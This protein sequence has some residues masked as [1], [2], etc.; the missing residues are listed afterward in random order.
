MAHFPNCSHDLNS[1]NVN[2]INS[3][4]KLFQKVLSNVFCNLKNLHLCRARYMELWVFWITEENKWLKLQQALFT[5]VR[6]PF[7]KHGPAPGSTLYEVVQIHL[8][9][10]ELYRLYYDCGSLELAVS[11]NCVILWWTPITLERP[12]LLEN[13]YI[14]NYFSVQ[15]M[16]LSKKQSLYN[17]EVIKE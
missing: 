3:K 11:G 1:R 14:L 13:N 5:D 15:I 9:S 7:E 2:S 16:Y 4:T 6:D 10:F 8:Y 17:L 12:F